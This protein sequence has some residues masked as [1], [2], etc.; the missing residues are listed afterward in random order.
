MG[1]NSNGRLRQF[2]D[3]F[4]WPATTAE[5]DLAA[6]QMDTTWLSRSLS[7]IHDVL[8]SSTSKDCGHKLDDLNPFLNLG[9]KTKKCG[10]N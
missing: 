1:V 6:V 8:R 5:G 2:D 3:H 4:A 7:K 10:F 9:Y